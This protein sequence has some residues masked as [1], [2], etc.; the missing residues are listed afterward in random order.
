MGICAVGVHRGVECHVLL[1]GGLTSAQPST[2]VHD[3]SRAPLAQRSCADTVRFMTVL[4]PPA[5]TVAYLREAPSQ[6]RC[7][8]VRDDGWVKPRGGLWTT[9]GG[10]P[11]WQ[12]WCAQDY[13]AGVAGCRGWTWDVRPDARLWVVDTLADL[14]D[15]VARFPGR[16]STAV[17]P[18]ISFE[19]MQAQGFDGM[20][21]TDRGQSDTRI[22]PPGYPSLYGWDLETVLLFHMD[23]VTNQRR[24]D[25]GR[26]GVARVSVPTRRAQTSVA[27]TGGRC[28]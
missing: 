9:P 18:T 4:R 21:L 24:Y 5:T 8:P 28:R 11:T 12:Q 2:V 15:T 23:V 25:H 27:H 6:S 26:A 10:A 14:V 22:P 1:D 19:S 13:P 3:G 7:T 20:W 17:G 16:I